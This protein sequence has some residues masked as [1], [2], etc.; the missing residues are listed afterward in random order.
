MRKSSSVLYNIFCSAHN[1]NF[2]SVYVNVGDINYCE[3][4][5]KTVLY[6]RGWFR[7]RFQKC[8]GVLFISHGSK[9]TTFWTAFNLSAEPR[10]THVNGPGP[11]GVV[12]ALADDLSTTALDTMSSFRPIKSPLKATPT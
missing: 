2:R 1:K 12:Q 8:T 3:C 7:S 11:E 6:G 9:R 5:T 4:E 10:T